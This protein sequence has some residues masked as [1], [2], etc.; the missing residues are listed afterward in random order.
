MATETEQIRLRLDLG[1]EADDEDSLSN[2]EIDAIFVEAGESYTDAASIKAY[3][4][5]LAIERLLMQAASSVDYTQNNTTEKA[6]Q[7]STQLERRLAKW[8]KKLAEAVDAARTSAARF[9]R[10]KRKPARIYEYP[11]EWYW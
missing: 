2:D 1:L 4:R 8:E 10:T 11:G 5:I 6:S 3:T 9:G 7:R